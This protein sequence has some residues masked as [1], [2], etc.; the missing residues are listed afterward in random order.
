MLWG[1]GT[2]AT[3]NPARFLLLAGVRSLAPLPGHWAMILSIAQSFVAS[4][5]TTCLFPRQYWG[6]SQTWTGSLVP[7]SSMKLS[8]LFPVSPPR[9][10]KL[11]RPHSVITWTFALY[12]TYPRGR[13]QTQ[14]SIASERCRLLPFI[15]SDYPAPLYF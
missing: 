7:N 6:E 2:A 13:G 3:Q 5:I 11:P 4:W 14:A 8:S 12:P 1:S 9:R 15:A 10:E